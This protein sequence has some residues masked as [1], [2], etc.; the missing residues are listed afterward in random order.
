MPCEGCNP[1]FTEVAVAG[2]LLNFS[3]RKLPAPQSVARFP[4]AIYASVPVIALPVTATSDCKLL[5]V[6]PNITVLPFSAATVTPVKGLP[7]LH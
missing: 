7:Q 1:T 2:I 6:L 3:A 4:D 5:T